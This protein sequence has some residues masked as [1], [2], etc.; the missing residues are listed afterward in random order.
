MTA[1]KGWNGVGK[2]KYLTKEEERRP[3]QSNRASD[4]FVIRS[5]KG[6]RGAREL[7]GEPKTKTQGRALRPQRLT[8]SVH[9]FGLPVIRIVFHFL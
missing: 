1:W 2:Q 9:V 3:Q 4:R 7:S 5:I 8:P 6:G